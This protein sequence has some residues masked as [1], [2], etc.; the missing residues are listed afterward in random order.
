[1]KQLMQAKAYGVQITQRAEA[2][3]RSHKSLILYALSL[4]QLLHFLLLNSLPPCERCSF[5]RNY[6]AVI[7]LSLWTI[8]FSKIK[9]LKIPAGV[10]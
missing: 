2:L 10:H 1:M 7:F 8:P 6:L 3:Y 4:F 5:R 9:N